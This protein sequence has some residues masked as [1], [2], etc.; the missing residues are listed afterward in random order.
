[1]QIQEKKK[2]YIELKAVLERQ[3]GPEVVEQLSIYEHTLK[4]NTRQLKAMA[5]ELSIFFFLYIKRK[6]KEGRRKKKEE[7]RFLS[8][9]FFLL[10]SDKTRHTP[11]HCETH[12]KSREKEMKKKGF[13]NNLQR[14]MENVQE[15]Q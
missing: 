15:W 3:P 11:P 8:S 4:D 14:K 5:S 7:R 6:K 13:R 10:L 2:L 9:F 1:M 12:H